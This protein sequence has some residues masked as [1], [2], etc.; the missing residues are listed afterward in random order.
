MIQKLNPMGPPAPHYKYTVMVDQSDRFV[1]LP[2]NH[3]LNQTEFAAKVEGV[4]IDAGLSVVAVP[5]EKKTIE[6]RKDD[7]LSAAGSRSS[8]ASSEAGKRFNSVRI[9]RYTVSTVIN[10]EYIVETLLKDSY[11]TLK[12]TRVSDNKILSVLT[13]KGSKSALEKEIREK[14]VAMKFVSKSLLPN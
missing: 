1:V 8:G 5:Q 6:E 10:A 3:R 7:G 4:L 9:E 14:L 2:F 12:F 13:L 11:G